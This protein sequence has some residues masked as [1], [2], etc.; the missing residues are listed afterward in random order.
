MHGRGSAAIAYADGVRPRWSRCWAY[1]RLL[2]AKRLGG[3]RRVCAKQQ[4]RDS[5]ERSGRQTVLTGPGSNGQWQG[6]QSLT[7]TA[8]PCC[9]DDV[10]VLQLVGE[11]DLCT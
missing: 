3:A 5:Q 2:V 7:V 1:R 8:Q 9:A 11:V 6:G 10:L 4:H